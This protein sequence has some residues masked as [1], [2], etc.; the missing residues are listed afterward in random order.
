MTDCRNGR[1]EQVCADC[2]FEQG[3]CQWE[4]VSFGP[5]SWLRGRG[6]DQMQTHVGPVVDRTP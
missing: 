2:T 1:D 6:V 5:F 3:Y 4:D